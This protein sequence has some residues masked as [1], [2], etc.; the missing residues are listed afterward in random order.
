VVIPRRQFRRS[1]KRPAENQQQARCAMV[2]TPLHDRNPLRIIPY[3]RV[4]L[5]II[6]LCCMLFLVSAC[7]PWPKRGA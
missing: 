4:T 5:S 1:V 6:A 7:F 3:Q 2:F